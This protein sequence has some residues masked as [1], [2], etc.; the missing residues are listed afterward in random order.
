VA[1]GSD[2][3]GAVTVPFDAAGLVHLTD[4]L[5]GAGLDEPAIRLVMGENV[6]RVLGEALPEG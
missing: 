3:D 4:E 1:L 6:L 5:L 2:W